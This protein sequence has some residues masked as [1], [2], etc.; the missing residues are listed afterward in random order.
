[1]N[2]H[3]LNLWAVLVAAASAFVLG[4]LWYSP[5]AFG[6][7][8]KKANRFASDPPGAR[9]QGICNG[10]CAEP[11]HGSQPGDVSERSQDE[12]GLGSNC[13]LSYVLVN[14]GYMTAALVLMGV[15][16]GAWR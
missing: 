6:T 1:M 16:L 12:P 9:G 7:V 2:L 10:V 13:R 8:W 4:G 14:G 15:I 3:T 11:G 5:L